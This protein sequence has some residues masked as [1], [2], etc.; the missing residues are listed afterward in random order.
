[1]YAN[2]LVWGDEA[3]KL[4]RHAPAGC[5]PRSGPRQPPRQQR[6]HQGQ[7]PLTQHGMRRSARMA[8]RAA[9]VAPQLGQGNA[10]GGVGVE[11]PR[12][13][14]L[15]LYRERHIVGQKVPAAVACKGLIPPLSSMGMPITASAVVAISLRTNMQRQLSIEY[16]SKVKIALLKLAREGNPGAGG[17]THWPFR[18]RCIMARSSTP[19]AWLSSWQKGRRPVS[20]RNSTTPAAHTSTSAASYGPRPRSTYACDRAVLL[21]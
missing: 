16:C 15:R 5:P 1:M 18:M 10:L 2:T 9:R 8:R 17:S 3:E 12:Q 4:A 13:H 21:W 11:Y 20:I 14:V 6:C 7:L 19:A